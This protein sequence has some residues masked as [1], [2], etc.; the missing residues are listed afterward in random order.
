MEVFLPNK[1]DTSSVD[2]HHDVDESVTS[3]ISP[4]DTRKVDNN[5]PVD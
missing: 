5:E 1:D 3:K 4:M 2:D